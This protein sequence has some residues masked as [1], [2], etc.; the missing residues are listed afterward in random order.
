MESPYIPQGWSAR[1]K[2]LHGLMYA[3]LAAS[4]MAPQIFKLSN[5]ET[6]KPSNLQTFKRYLLTCVSVTLYGALMEALQRFCTLTR[7]GEI[8]DIVADFLG[9][10]L[11][12]GIVVLFA[13]I[14]GKW[15]M[16]HDKSSL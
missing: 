9:A 15:Y 7:S 8:A 13:I 1:D 4:W 12:A 5:P 14:H 2:L 11:G 10:I 3:F 16:V 6:L